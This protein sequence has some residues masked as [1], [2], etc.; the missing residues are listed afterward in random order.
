MQ[1][2]VY[3]LCSKPK[4]VLYIGVTS[5]LKKRV[6][7]HR[8]HYVDGFTKKYNVTQLVYFE[9]HEQMYSA[10]CREKQL[11]NWRRQWKLNLIQQKNPEWMDLYNF[12]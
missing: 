10:L 3:I 11:K 6:Y 1:P 4:G 12:I 5:N 8:Q 2:A 9:C 7:E